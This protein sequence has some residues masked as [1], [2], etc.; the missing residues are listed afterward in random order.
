MTDTAN[1]W[2]QDD[3]R[4]QEVLDIVVKETGIAKGR[5][6]PDATIVSLDIASLDMVQAIF[7]IESRFDVEIPVLSEHSGK[8][9]ET[10]GELVG[11]AL[12]AIDAKSMS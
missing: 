10:M 11:Q 7:A 6:T 9:A 2:P 4:V 3:A 1:V 8:E 5:L 12:A